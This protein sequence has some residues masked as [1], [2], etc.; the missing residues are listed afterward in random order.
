MLLSRGVP[1]V[2]TGG[3]SGGAASPW[4]GLGTQGGRERDGRAASGQFSLLIKTFCRRHWAVREISPEVSARKSK[5]TFSWA[6]VI[7]EGLKDLSRWFLTLT[8]LH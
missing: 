3:G 4:L 8:W 2:G 5:G 1:W 6:T 7:C